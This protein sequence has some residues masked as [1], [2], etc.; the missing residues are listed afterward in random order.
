MIISLIAAIGKNKVIGKGNSLP[1]KLPADMKRFKELTEGKP[2]IMGRK[3]F[4]SIGK[5]LPKRKNIILTRDQDYRAENCIVV[6]SIEE[7]LE[8]AENNEEIMI[9]GGAQV[10]REFLPKAD[11]MYLT[12]IDADFEGDAYFPEYK[13]EEWD[14]TSYEEHEMDKDNPHDYVFLVLERR[15]S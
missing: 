9:I 14:E 11:R 4:E 5:P 10:Y 6:H 2:V 8:A 12:L 13:I 15:Q 3:T 7:A 1:W